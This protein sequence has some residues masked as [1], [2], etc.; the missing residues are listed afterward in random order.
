LALQSPTALP[1][2]C[3][4]TSSESGDGLPELLCN[5]LNLTNPLSAF[6]VTINTVIHLG[7]VNGR[8]S[9][10]FSNTSMIMWCPNICCRLLRVKPAI[11][12]SAIRC[13]HSV[14][15]CPS[16][17]GLRWGD[18]CTIAWCRVAAWPTAAGCCC[19]SRTPPTSALLLL[20]VARWMT[21]SQLLPLLL[22][23]QLPQ[24]VLTGRT[25]AVSYCCSRCRC[26]DCGIVDAATALL[27]LSAFVGHL[28]YFFVF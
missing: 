26:G 11:V 17:Q 27:L 21:R 19:L 23:L 6:K 25:Q 5:H 16:C 22:P 14:D 3:T 18:V 7:G 12:W 9:T 8:G 10:K 15:P 24:A 20:L 2:S 1:N 4:F 28:A 13:S